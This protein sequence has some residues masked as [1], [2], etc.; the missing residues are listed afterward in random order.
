MVNILQ[1]VVQLEIMSLRFSVLVLLLVSLKIIPAIEN[2]RIPHAESAGPV[3]ADDCPQGHFS[4][5]VVR[6]LYKSP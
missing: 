2:A 5:V 6:F 3:T 4:N 1:G